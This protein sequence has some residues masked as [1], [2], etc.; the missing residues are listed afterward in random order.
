MRECECLINRGGGVMSYPRSL[1]VALI[2]LAIAGVGCN[3]NSGSSP[4]GPS[5]APQS[6]R[7]QYTAYD[8]S[9]ATVATGTLTFSLEGSSVAGQ[10]DI[11]GNAPEAGTGT[12]SGQ[13][14]ADGTV[15][16]ELNPAV[17]FDVVLQGKFEGE[18]LTGKRLLDTGDPPIDRAIGTF[19]LSP[20]STG[21]H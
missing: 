13:E 20:P 15:Q 7:Y 4:T 17:A 19:V 10:R 8:A 5:G 21:T 3:S 9:G 18:V 2:A 16:I 6:T 11:K 12:I 14:L 1:I